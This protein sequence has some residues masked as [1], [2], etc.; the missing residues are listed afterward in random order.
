[1]STKRCIGC[2]QVLPLVAFYPHHRDGYTSRCRDCSNALNR[3]R[4]AERG[5]ADRPRPTSYRRRALLGVELGPFDVRQ[6]RMSKIRE[7]VARRRGE[8]RKVG[9]HAKMVRC[10]LPRRPETIAEIR[11]IHMQPPCGALVFGGEEEE[12]A[13]EVHGVSGEGM[14]VPVDKQG[15]E[16]A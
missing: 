13:L 10:M 2:E 15:E 1:M 6:E 8:G 14:F 9:L 7:R 5:R 16:A 11:S 3:Q 12:H 4:Y